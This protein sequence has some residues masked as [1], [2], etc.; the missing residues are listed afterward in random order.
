MSLACILLLA[1]SLTSDAYPLATNNHFHAQ[2]WLDRYGFSV[3]CIDGVWG[4][5]SARAK[6]LFEKAGGVLPDRPFPVKLVKVTAMDVNELVEI[7]PT[8]EEKADL[9][10]MG[11]STLKEMYAERGH[12]S[13]KCLEKINPEIADWSKVR[14]G[15][16]IRIP[17]I[18]AFRPEQKAAILKVS[19]K[20]CEIL[21]F[22]RDGKL[23]AF[24]PCSIAASKANLPPHGELSVTSHIEN[25]NYTFTPDTPPPDGGKIKRYILEPGP[26]NPV[27]LAWIGLGGLD[28][29]GYGI[30][31]T[32]NPES[33][34]NAESHGCFR[35]ANWNALRLYRLTDFDTKVIVEP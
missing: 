10:Y 30:H 7:P 21:A 14:V 31:G 2:C 19:L 8:P 26:N 25:P 17:D 34:G 28:L 33:V 18:G 6:E 9:E 11:Y 29:Q 23:L 20:R 12:V 22:D 13:Q 4:Q 35:V 15:D 27:G 5:K 24:F 1:A 32:P 16:K 3:N